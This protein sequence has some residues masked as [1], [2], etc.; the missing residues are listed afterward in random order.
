MADQVDLRIVVSA[1][2]ETR[3]VLQNLANEIN[4]VQKALGKVN[5]DSTAGLADLG[6]EVGKIG[7]NAAQTTLRTTEM[8]FGLS[9]L[10]GL[11]NGLATAFKLVTGGVLSFGF[12]AI[13]KNV[14]DT[15]ARTEVLGAVLGTIAR[16][17]GLTEARIN[18][19]DQEIRKLGITAE[20]SRQSL[21]QLVQAGLSLDLAPRLA[22][23]AQDL[24]VIS[25][26]NSSETLSRMVVNIQQMDSLG[27]RWMGIMI[28]REQAF[29]RAEAE[30]GRALD[31][32]LKQ[33][34]FA[35][36]VL[37]ESVKLA[38]IYEASM[39][40]V[41]K[42]LSSQA[43]LYNEL[44]VAIG[45]GLLPVYTEV[46]RGTNNFLSALTKLFDGTTS[47]AKQFNV[48][49]EEIKKVSPIITALSSAIAGFYT[50]LNGTV[51]AMGKFIAA[52]TQLNEVLPLN[53]AVMLGIV[54]LTG[55]LLLS[56]TVVKL[57]LAKLAI[58]LA[59]GPAAWGLIGAAMLPVIVIAAKVAAALLAAGL[60]VRGAM[61]AFEAVQRF[62]T[63]SGN[64]A[65]KAV[66]NY[67]K[68]STRAKDIAKQTAEAVRALGLVELKI[69]STNPEDT[70]E[71]KKLEAE[72]ARLNK[73]ISDLKTQQ[74]AANKDLQ[75]KR[76]EAALVDP[77][78]QAGKDLADF[79]ERE[80]A[81][82]RTAE[83]AKKAEQAATEAMDKLGF[84]MF[85]DG[86][87]RIAVESKGIK[88]SIGTI[89]EALRGLKD[90]SGDAET[91]FRNLFT[92][93][94]ENASKAAT[95][96]D[97][98]NIGKLVDEFKKKAQDLGTTLTPE[99]IQSA[100]G[101]ALDFAAQ[102]RE[103]AN[104]DLL[105][106]SSAAANEQRGFENAQLEARR[107]AAEGA[108]QIT[109]SQIQVDRSLLE[110]QRSEN[111][112][113]EQTY[114][115]R[116][117][118]LRRRERAV[119]LADLAI[120]R[121]AV[122]EK[123]ASD[124]IIGNRTERTR[125]QTELIQIE[126][127]RQAIATEAR[128]DEVEVS[129]QELA[130]AKAR[131]ASIQA[132]FLKTVDRQN[133]EE[134][135]VARVTAEY[136]AK[137]EAAQKNP[138]ELQLIEANRLADTEK[139]RL[140]FALK[141]RDL[142]ADVLSITD[143]LAGRIE[144][145]RLQYARMREENKGAGPQ[146]Q[147]N[148]N[149]LEADAITQA[150]REEF[151][152]IRDLKIEV[153]KITNTEAAEI[154]AINARYDDQLNAMRGIKGAAEDIE[155]LRAAAIRKANDNIETRRLEREL[156]LREQMLSIQQAQVNLAQTRGQ[157]TTLQAQDA[158]N[159]LTLER[160]DNI[161]KRIAQTR[162]RLENQRSSGLYSPEDISASETLLNNLTQQLVDLSAQVKTLGDQFR[163]SF[164][165]GLD[166]YLK[167]IILRTDT[168]SEAWR[169]F[170]QTIS[171]TLLSTA[172]KNAS[173]LF[174]GV[175]AK[176]GANEQ[177]QGGIFD[178]IAGL[179]G[180]GTKERGTKTN[181]MYVTFSDGLRSNLL[182]GGGGDG[183]LRF[184]S[185]SQSDFVGPPS[186]A[187]GSGSEAFGLLSIF[188][189][190]LKFAEGGRV[191]GPGT[192]TSDSIP[193]LASNGEHIMPAEKTKKWLPLLEGIR[194]GTVRDA[195]SLVK[196]VANLPRFA[197]GGLVGV[198]RIPTM[199]MM[200]FAAG[201]VVP[202]VNRGGDTYK[203]NVDTG[204]VSSGP[205]GAVPQ[206]NLDQFGNLLGAMVQQQIVR[207]KRPGGLL[208]GG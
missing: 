110:A 167:D 121:R 64:N 125:L 204:G 15:A 148:I 103:R 60:V 35:N 192:G 43:R 95:D 174:T 100:A 134:A 22:R 152:K 123:L 78:S 168:A 65:Q 25:G 128:K 107:A 131:S 117:R 116:V 94:L 129:Q 180:V 201:G 155:K 184:L 93:V 195:P 151:V 161:Q 69:K 120:Q 142:E 200:R 118:A 23:A 141:R 37:E 190:F 181:P 27:L 91:S 31:N 70:E 178:Q 175:I 133:S 205:G 54:A 140:D 44:N 143:S 163:E 149:T 20:S 136:E 41:S 42:M 106:G 48:F 51:D 173:E 53:E 119:D 132:E 52:W 169:K 56:F 208:Y 50:V 193:I 36:A 145:I 80:A 8:A 191:S 194:L 150:Q 189:R 87:K 146:V 32:S 183:L 156:A 67:V 45:N 97:V 177:G 58:V 3:K 30:L 74:D 57:V 162:E 59:A 38:G 154:A 157:I 28:N 165:E 138:L 159:V 18:A 202:N 83:A 164:Q 122:Q 39:E 197:F 1:V 203:I 76:K 160:M 198:P 16:N 127:R 82:Q 124:S 29:A 24:A 158:R 40:N 47:G 33:Q 109:R 2:D 92:T 11:A 196:L 96:T 187:A 104:A 206:Q 72:K 147:A 105:R 166:Q 71:L 26:T 88:E 84:S 77:A 73:V 75:K 85:R 135:A 137:A 21:T 81:A 185:E 62:F 68:A 113:S 153:Q 17:A 101:L 10:T 199:P 14:A 179:F 63:N 112:I 61:A 13:A 34:V 86:N 172:T 114:F 111:M 126:L 66:D 89:S 188:S 4:A 79:N 90:S 98:K 5:G 115:Q 19:A 176:I 207:E 108:N 139:V 102:Q 171:N 6:K 99:Q 49:G 130:A 12:L 7:Q 186:S 46:V 55:K 170:R 144:K 182:G 9:R